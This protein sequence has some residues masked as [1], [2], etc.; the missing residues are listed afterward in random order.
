MFTR[1]CLNSFAF[2]LVALIVVLSPRAWGAEVLV[3]QWVES[4]SYQSNYFRPS[5]FNIVI[6]ENY[7]YL[8]DEGYLRRSYTPCYDGIRESCSI[9]FEIEEN[10]HFEILTLSQKRIT[11]EQ[12]QYLG[13]TQLELRFSG[14]RPLQ[15]YRMI[16]GY[17][18][19]YGGNVKWVD[20]DE[21]LCRLLNR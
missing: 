2:S 13:K 21:F 7:A 19:G 3:C 16:T 9:D 17:L 12:R 8:E 15:K 14:E 6:N 1:A 18:Y 11:I 20:G 10:R 5:G 4:T